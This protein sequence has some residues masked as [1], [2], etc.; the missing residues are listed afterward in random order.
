LA[1]VDQQ[2]G[3]VSILLGTGDAR[4]FGW[5]NF[6]SVG[7]NPQGIAIGDF[8]QDGML[9]LAVSNSGDGTVSILLGNGDGTFQS[10]QIVPLPASVRPYWLVSADLR[11][12]GTLDLVVPDSGASNQV[13][14]LLG[15]G[16][17]SFQPAVGYAVDASQYGVSVG[18]MNGDGI[19]DLVVPNSAADAQVSV[20]LGDGNGTFAAKTDYTVG[21]NPTFVALADFNGDGLPDIA[22]ANG[23]SSNATILLQ[24]R[25]ET[26][27][28]TGVAVFPAG[29]HNVLASYP[30]DADRSSSRSATVALMGSSPTP[31]STLLAATPNPAITPQTVSLTATVT[32]VPTGSAVGTVS[33]YSGTTLL[34]SVNLNSS[35]VAAFST[36]S[37]PVG[38]DTLTAGYSGNTAF[39]TS[40]SNP[41]LETIAA[42]TSTTTSLA[43][44]PNPATALQT[45]SL[46]ATVAPIPTGSAI[47]TVSFYSGTTLLGSV[48][49]N[50]SGIA[51]FS[52]TSLPVGVD[53]L[54]AVYSGNVAFTTSTSNP[55]TETI[56]IGSSFESTFMV[57][58]QPTSVTVPPSGSATINA[59]V[60]PSGG[61][62]NNVVMMSA[63]GLPPGATA[64]F[65]PP[66]VIPGGAGAPTVLT[67]QWGVVSSHVDP[68]RKI[69]FGSFALTL[70]LCGM[71]FRHKGS[72]RGLKR[73]LA[74]LSLACMAFTLLGC[75][76]G[77]F[78]HSSNP[79]PN[80]YVVTITGTSGSIQSSA[81]VT[82]VVP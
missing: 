73:A 55:L 5:P 65:S 18:D 28:A 46:T 75:G 1:V 81:T 10:Q 58:A 52:T 8:N 39:A 57:M 32:P 80:S 68:L 51:T 29:T 72:S 13:Y 67:T 76:G 53:T 70:G 40:T 15:N 69:S 12:S 49:L 25:T 74:F 26:A 64:S 14:V 41:V 56:Y 2:E 61:A 19:M 24:A 60:L 31:T 47:G 6:Y 11:N 44:S 35:G 33:F 63:T 62:F 78:L 20:L 42:V 7:S 79:Q 82:V 50:S 66:S 45:V 37:L 34:G 9:D 77:G 54:T 59:S 3:K 30:G 4:L 23:G 38:V 16:D 17:G 22:T 48:N 71:G 21:N 27:T 36:T 43:A